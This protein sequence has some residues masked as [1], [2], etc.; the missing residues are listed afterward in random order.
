MNV[1]FI[2]AASDELDGAI[3]YYDGQRPG[4]GEEFRTEVDA[5]LDRIEF[6]PNA[7]SRASNEARVCKTKRFPFG[8][9]YCSDEDEIVVI[10]V[11]HLHRRPGYWKKRMRDL[12]P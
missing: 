12:D 3:R 2:K 10:A 1:R 9:V 11:M 5:A 4:L 6:W 8:V 7:W